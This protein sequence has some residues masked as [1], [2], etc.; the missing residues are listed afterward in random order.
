[1][2]NTVQELS[3]ETTT[4]STGIS[5]L[6]GK[7][8]LKE[9]LKAAQ[10]KMFFHQFAY[11]A[12]AGPGI[13]DV[14]VPIASTNKNMTDSKSEAAARTLTE[15]DNLTAVTFTP[16]SHNFGVAISAEVV[17]TS[18]VDVVAFAR[19]QMA[20][21]I[22][23]DIDGAFAT[24]ITAATPATTLYGGDATSVG[25]LATGDI[26]TTD[27]LAT[28]QRALKVN[29]W[30]SEPDKPIVC[31]ISPY[32]EEA[33]MK[34]SQFVNAAE[35]GNNEVVMNG[36]IG[37]YLGMKVIS[38]NQV[39]SYTATTAWGVA[40]HQCFVL[41][42]KVAYGI[43]YGQRPKLDWEYKKNEAATFIYLDASYLCDSLQDG[44]IVHIDVSD[45]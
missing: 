36:E 26:L 31:F 12:D 29:G 33:L 5:D 27:L 22:A 24:A 1:M 4:S 34:D 45:A 40:G 44:A 3:N 25:D 15:I 20:Y 2:K 43:V 42:A 11:V 8:W 16:T 39:T 9:V 17:R 23:L 13:K 28:A 14:A 10:Q 18:Q 6:Q 30:V 19:E 32:Q 41:K 38:T 35:Y 21:A 37:K 7:R